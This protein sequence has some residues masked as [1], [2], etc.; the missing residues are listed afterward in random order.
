MDAEIPVVI[1]VISEYRHII[2][3]ALI[4]ACLPMLWKAVMSVFN[5]DGK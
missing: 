1:A 2:M 3:P 4:L 5:G